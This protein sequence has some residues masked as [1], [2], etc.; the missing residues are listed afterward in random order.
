MRPRS[1][2]GFGRGE[3]SGPD[4][5]WT[6][7]LRSVNHRFLDCRI[8]LPKQC[9][10]L[11]ERL[12]Q[13]IAARYE[14]G[15]VDVSCSLRQDRQSALRP[16]L[17]LSL[18][19]GYLDC[20]RRLGEE[21]YL[22]QEPGLEHLLQFRDI[23]VMREESPD[24][25]ALAASLVEALEA[26][27][28]GCLHMREQEGQSLARDLQERLNRF[29]A[30]VELLAGRLPEVRRQRERSLRERLE[31]SLAGLTLDPA[32]LTQEAAL[33]ADKSDVTE[34]LVRL[35]S[36][37]DQFGAFLAADEPVGRRLDFL[38]QEFLREVNTLASKIADAAVAQITV[39]LKN[40]IEKIREQVQNLE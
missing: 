27:L 22:P 28:D 19:R 21:L 18:A 39:E 25:E 40:E 13:R 31:R 2:T 4:H 7:E 32:R 23:I 34:E 30:T 17:D 24:M 37:I 16:E 29:A 9:T 3:A 5:A 1:M 36:H 6:V 38:L 10:V 14:R 33:L 12:R 20:L 26:A 8:L 15:R 35:R 11:E